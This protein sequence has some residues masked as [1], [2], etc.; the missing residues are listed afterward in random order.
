M[1]KIERII[2]VE[3][4]QNHF[5]LMNFSLTELG[6]ERSTSRTLPINISMTLSLLRSKSSLIMLIYYWVYL[7]SAASNYL[8]SFY[9]YK[10]IHYS[11]FHLFEL[12]FLV[13]AVLAHF[14]VCG[15]FGFFEFSWSALWWGQNNKRNWGSSCKMRYLYFWAFW[16]MLLASSSALSSSSM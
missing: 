9:A 7:S 10:H 3:L 16:M 1:T 8:S 14:E 5:F 4:G 6:I 15:F 2:N 11:F 12:G 13:L